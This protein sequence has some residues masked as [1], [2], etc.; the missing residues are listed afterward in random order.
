MSRLAVLADIHGNLTALEAVFADLE[1]V[2]VTSVLCLGDVASFGP[3]PREALRRLRE[4]N[5]QLVMG[6]TDAYLLKP[7]TL[8][9]VTKP[10]ADTPVILAIEAWSAE[11]LDEEDLAYVRGFAPTVR[12]E[13]GG[14]EI[15]AYHGSPRSYHDPIRA[16]TADEMLDGYFASEPAD[17]YLGAH[18]H[19]QFVRRYRAAILMN[20]GSVGLSFVALAGEG[21]NYPVAEYALVEVAKGLPNIALRRVPYDLGALTA[22]VHESN[23]PHP[24][25]WLED[26]RPVPL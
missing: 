9:D 10:D 1:R 15:L 4:L 23:M 5:P 2:E 14:R 19:E 6:N 26:F 24:E 25:R 16:T 17:L 13:L 12:L 8:E 22:A 21:V 20:P 7:R 18:T 11:Q 3:Q